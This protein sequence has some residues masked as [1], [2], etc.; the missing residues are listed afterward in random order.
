MFS[1]SKAYSSYSVND[2]AKAKDFYSNT[3]GLM[4]EDDPMGILEIQL[5]S[6][7]RIMLYPKDDH[8]PATFT[9]LNFNVDNIDEAVEKL[10]T[11]GIKTEQYKGDIQTDDKGIFRGENGLAIAWF[12]DPAGNILSIIQENS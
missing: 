4:G 5:E 3:L 9:V 11:A 6:G 7:S 2:L 10:L 8:T 12:K 1:H